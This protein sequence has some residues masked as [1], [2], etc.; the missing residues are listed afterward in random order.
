MDKER[1]EQ[2]YILLE[3]IEKEHNAEVTAAL[4]WAIFKLESR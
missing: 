3:R 4:R 1:I 2:L